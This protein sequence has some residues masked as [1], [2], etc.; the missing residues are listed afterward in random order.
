[1]FEMANIKPPFSNLEPTAALFHIGAQGTLIDDIP[2][3]LGAAGRDLVVRC[4]AK[5]PAQRPTCA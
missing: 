2:A 3:S 4:M 1:M 5:D